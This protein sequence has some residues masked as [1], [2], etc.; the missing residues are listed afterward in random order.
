MPGLVAIDDKVCFTYLYLHDAQIK[1]MT[2]SA[3]TKETSQRDSISFNTCSFPSPSNT[4]PASFC[5][6]AGGKHSSRVSPFRTGTNAASRPPT[7]SNGFPIAL[8]CAM[9]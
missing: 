4:S 9:T 7:L 8:S 6:S 5:T 3:P 2:S 1:S